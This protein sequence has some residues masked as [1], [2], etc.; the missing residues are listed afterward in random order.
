MNPSDFERYI[1]NLD[2]EGIEQLTI[3][4]LLD[5]Y[6]FFNANRS[7]FKLKERFEFILK[8]VHEFKVK[9]GRTKT[10]I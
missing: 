5:Q 4:M 6:E 3:M 8:Q 2:R 7:T 9:Y 1:K 10:P